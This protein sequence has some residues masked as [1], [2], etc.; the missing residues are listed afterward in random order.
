MVVCKKQHQRSWVWLE[1]LH[2]GNTLA[3]TTVDDLF[4]FH[5]FEVLSFNSTDRFTSSS[6]T[7][8]SSDPFE[9]REGRRRTKIKG[10]L[11]MCLFLGFS[12]GNF[13]S[14]LQNRTLYITT[15]VCKKMSGY[16]VKLFTLREV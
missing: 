2:P 12:N 4:F 13:S 5:H 14:D 7:L 15:K 16:V 6:S 3:S 1:R 10:K 11:H 8:P 9:N